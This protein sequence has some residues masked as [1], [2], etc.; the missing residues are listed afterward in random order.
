MN[1]QT[2]LISRTDLEALIGRSLTQTEITNYD[3]YLNIAGMRVSDLVCYTLEPVLPADLAL[4]VARCFDVIS[5][6]NS[7]RAGVSSKRVEDFSITYDSSA[8]IF[9]DFLKTNSATLA[10]YS[11]CQGKFESGDLYGD[12]IRC[13]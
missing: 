8:D 6:E 5:V 13:I 11:K 12:C 10:K 2:P 7:R 1:E 3:L 9:G 4:V